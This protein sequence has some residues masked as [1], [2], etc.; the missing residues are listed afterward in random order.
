M[1]FCFSATGNSLYAARCLDSEVVSIPQLMDRDNLSF[2]AERIGIVAPIYGH[3]MPEMVKEFIRRADFDT[4]YLYLVLTYGCRHASAVELAENV[5]RKAGKRPDYIHTLLMVDNFLPAFDM[6]QQ[7]NLDKDVEGQIRSIRRDVEN[8]KQ[9]IEAVTPEDREAHASYLETVHHM[10]ETVW[11]DFRFT[12]ECIGCGICTKVCPAGCIRLEHGRAVRTG[13]NCQACM[14]CIHACPE[15]AI[16]LNPVFGFEE[17][18]PE[19]RYRNE[20]ITLSDLV[21][22]NWRRSAEQA[23]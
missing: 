17:P 15:T 19:A 22:A 5:F 6:W 2:R 11:A 9:E 23:G 21:A 4:G 1:V 8:Q 14:A 20:N 7:M 10:P 13:R 12:E 18:N 3:E 16:R